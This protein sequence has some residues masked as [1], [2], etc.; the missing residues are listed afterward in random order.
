MEKRDRQT[1]KKMIEEQVPILM[2]ASVKKEMKAIK[3]ELLAELKKELKAKPE[4]KPA[5]KEA[6]SK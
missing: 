6:K 3:R 5:K 2:G 4:P 1:V